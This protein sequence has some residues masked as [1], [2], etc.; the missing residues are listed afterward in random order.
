VG[1][2]AR[3][4]GST[5]P[6]AAARSASRVPHPA[7]LPPAPPSTTF[8]AHPTTRH[9]A[10]VGTAKDEDKGHRSPFPYHPMTDL[11]AYPASSV[12]LLLGFAPA[13]VEMRRAAPAVLPWVFSH[14]C[15]DCPRILSPCLDKRRAPTSIS[16]SQYTS[17][18]T[19]RCTSRSGSVASWRC[20][21][22]RCGYVG[23]P[24][25]C[26]RRCPGQRW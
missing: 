25:A 8:M 14:G 12:H 2:G 24:S 23:R 6:P 20:E 21:Y 15:A 5:S 1:P 17:L 11:D 13:Q 9:S 22:G 19:I 10:L 18:S 7:R 4:S 3:T 16:A 26:R